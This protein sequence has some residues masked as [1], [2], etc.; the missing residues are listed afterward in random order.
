MGKKNILIIG[1]SS[2]VGQMVISKLDRKKYNIYCTFNKTKI[3]NAEIKSFKVNLGNLRNAENFIVKIKKLKIKIDT[4]I[5][6]Q[7][8]IHAKNLDKYNNKKILELFNI[9][10]ISTIL[11]IKR[12]HNIFNKN[13]L[14]IFISSISAVKGSYDSIYAASKSALLGFSKSLSIWLA[15][16]TKFISICPGPINNTKMMDQFSKRRKNYHILN[17]PNKELLNPDDFSKIII[18]ILSPHW[19]HANGSIININGGIY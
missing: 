2:K 14:V 7:G 9:N 8:K 15:P 17:N 1:G 10:L 19:R 12:L 6:L 11:L 13:S 4:M 3:K 5:F 16:K 18:D